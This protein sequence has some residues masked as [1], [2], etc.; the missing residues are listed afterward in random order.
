[1]IRNYILCISE[2][3]EIYYMENNT[4]LTMMLEGVFENVQQYKQSYAIFFLLRTNLNA[5]NW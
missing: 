2:K 1:M 4:K 5:F 3:L